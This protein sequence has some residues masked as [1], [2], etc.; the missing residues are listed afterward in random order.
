MEIRVLKCHRT[1]FVGKVFPAHFT[2]AN[3]VSFVSRYGMIFLERGEYEII[4]E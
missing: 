3:G 4:A 2:F 1:E